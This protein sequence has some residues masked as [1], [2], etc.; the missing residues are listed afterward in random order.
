[1]SLYIFM[2]A[3]KVLSLGLI[4]FVSGYYFRVPINFNCFCVA[5]ANPHAGVMAP[6]FP[7]PWEGMGVPGEAG[8][9]HQGPA[10]HSGH[11]YKIANIFLGKGGAALKR[12]SWLHKGEEK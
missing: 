5:Q 12:S 6:V 11:K 10:V 8:Q 3:F 4:S 9:G 7:G 1:M 2:L